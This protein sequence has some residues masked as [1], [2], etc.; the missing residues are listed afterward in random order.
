MDQTLPAPALKCTSVEEVVEDW[1][2]PPAPR[3]PDPDWL[4]RHGH[5]I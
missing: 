2:W 5:G 3:E 4:H 1:F